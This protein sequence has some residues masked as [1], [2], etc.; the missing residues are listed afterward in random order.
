VSLLIQKPHS[1]S[2]HVQNNTRLIAAVRVN[3]GL[4]WMKAGESEFTENVVLKR[5]RT[6][7]D[8][9][10]HSSHLE[11]CPTSTYHYITGMQRRV[12]Q[13]TA[14]GQIQKSLALDHRKDRGDPTFVYTQTK[15]SLSVSEVG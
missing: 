3:A 13:S 1:T 6:E 10:R 7:S 15:P 14:Q 12:R 4:Y 9:P 11:P 5:N 2:I 8:Y